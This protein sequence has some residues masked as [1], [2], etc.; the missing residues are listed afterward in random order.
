MSMLNPYSDLP[1][2]WHAFVRFTTPVPPS[3]MIGEVS[4]S[5]V[6]GLVAECLLVVGPPRPMGSAKGFGWGL[7]KRA[8]AEERIA[9]WAAMAEAGHAWRERH[10]A[11]LM[12]FPPT[13]WVDG[14]AVPAPDPL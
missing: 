8:E 10:A 12:P 7:R 6:V 3:G 5:N 11:G 13:L 2:W 1:D 4:A 14:R 9:G